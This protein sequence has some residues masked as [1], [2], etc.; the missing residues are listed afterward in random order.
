MSNNLAAAYLRHLVKANEILAHM[1]LSLHNIGF[2]LDLMQ[3]M[4]HA[5]AEN[6]LKSF[7]EAFLSHYPEPS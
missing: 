6:R 3:E 7:A 1:L 4:R 2:L 5:I